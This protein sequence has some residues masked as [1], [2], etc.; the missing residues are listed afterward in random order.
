MYEKQSCR[1]RQC[2]TAYEYL[3]LYLNSVLQES[4]QRCAAVHAFGRQLPPRLRR[5]CLLD[6]PHRLEQR[7][8]VVCMN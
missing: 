5:S 4:A 8:R 3:I 7:L 6:G 2:N 1:L